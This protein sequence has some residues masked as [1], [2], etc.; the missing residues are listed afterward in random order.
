ME[1]YSSRHFKTLGQNGIEV[2]FTEPGSAIQSK[3]ARTSSVVNHTTRNVNATVASNTATFN[4]DHIPLVS[5]AIT[6]P[7]DALGNHLRSICESV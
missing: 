3:S 6:S 1:H 7:L 4:L 2:P 5:S